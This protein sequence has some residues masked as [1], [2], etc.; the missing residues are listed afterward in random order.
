MARQRGRQNGSKVTENINGLNSSQ[1]WVNDQL[2]RDVTC[3]NFSYPIGMSTQHFKGSYRII[4]SVLRLDV[5][6]T[7]GISDSVQSPAY[8][9]ARILFDKIVR[10]NNAT[11]PYDPVDL[12]LMMIAMSEV[13]GYW[14]CMQRIYKLSNTYDPMNI[15]MPETVLASMGININDIRKRK[16]ELRAWINDFALRMTTISFPS[17]VDLFARKDELYLGIYGDEDSQKAQFYVF[18]PVCFYKLSET[19]KNG[20]TLEPLPIWYQ[21]NNKTTAFDPKVQFVEATG[22]DNASWVP[23][24]V[25]SAPGGTMLDVLMNM[26]NEMLNA[27][28]GSSD[29]VRICADIR[30]AYS[31]FMTVDMLTEDAEC[32]R[33]HNYAML[34]Q[35][36]NARIVQPAKQIT[37]QD[38]GNPVDVGPYFPYFSQ[39]P[40][41]NKGY[42]TF[43]YH[44]TPTGLFANRFVLSTFDN[45]KSLALANLLRE[46]Y[47]YT[48]MLNL[49]STEAPD[50]DAIMI[51]TRLL[52]TISETSQIPWSLDVSACGTEIIVN[53]TPW[54]WGQQHSSE[55]FASFAY[56][57]LV[58]PTRATSKAVQDAVGNNRIKA[59]YLGDQFNFCPQRIMI[60]LSNLT[61]SMTGYDVYEHYDI[62]MFAF[63]D[64]KSLELLH[65]NALLGQ[66]RAPGYAYNSG[67]GTK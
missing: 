34:T 44:S 56:A 14:R 28:L 64:N 9:N 33:W 49:H 65:Y 62:D 15:S 25:T 48:K 50:A 13:Y 3:Y 5:Q 1:Y 29:V 23:R 32:G 66:F 61:S 57:S 11:P 42:L 31:S 37:S 51:M 30:N 46:A 20:T 27:L 21:K 12:Q 26:G 16:V 45:A 4:P 35:I 60:D 63:A 53:A 52:P 47:S 39:D 36:E 43:S 19:D 54:F 7:M 24:T 55:E 40:G 38:G 59:A 67:K 10:M 58:S 41:I 17:E 8:Q 18:Y 2:K 6:P 22:P